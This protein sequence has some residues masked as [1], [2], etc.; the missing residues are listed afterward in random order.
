M[1]CAS[2]K[3][4]PRANSARYVCEARARFVLGSRVKCAKQDARRCIEHTVAIDHQER[5][6]LRHYVPDELQPHDASQ[7]PVGGGRSI[8]AVDE[9]RWTLASPPGT[10]PWIPVCRVCRRHASTHSSWRQNVSPGKMRRRAPFCPWGSSP[11]RRC[12]GGLAPFMCPAFPALTCSPRACAAH[13]H[14]LLRRL[15]SVAPSRS[16]S[17]CSPSSW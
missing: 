13:A 16:S 3:G 17:S 5:E 10:R 7:T 11:T 14:Q 6:A 15:V 9:R 8:A 1:V 4:G 2:A 12:H